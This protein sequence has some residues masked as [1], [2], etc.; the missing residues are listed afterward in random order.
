MPLEVLVPDISPWIV[1]CYLMASVR[2]NYYLAGG[3]A[4]GA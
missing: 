3:F 4:Q 2:I 1:Q